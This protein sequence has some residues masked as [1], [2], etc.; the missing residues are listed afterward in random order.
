MQERTP[1]IIERADWKVWLGEG[2]VTRAVPPPTRP[3]SR[4]WQR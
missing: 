4:V 3:L 2:D 1:V